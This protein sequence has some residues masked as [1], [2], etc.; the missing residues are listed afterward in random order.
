MAVN[1]SALGVHLTFDLLPLWIMYKRSSSRTASRRSASRG[2]GLS[3][4]STSKMPLPI[5]LHVGTPLHRTSSQESAARNRS[6]QSNVPQIADMFQTFR[7]ISA[8]MVSCL[9]ICLLTACLL[10]QRIGT[11]NRAS[12]PTPILRSFPTAKVTVLRVRAL[13]LARQKGEHAP[14]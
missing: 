1:T 14:L 12:L 7:Y 4:C 3:A 13:Y 8:A 6:L 10:K 2:W 9:L 5:T 11:W